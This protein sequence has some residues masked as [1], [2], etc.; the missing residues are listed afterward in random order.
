MVILFIGM[1]SINKIQIRTVVGLNFL[2]RH[3]RS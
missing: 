2:K 1:I 3:D